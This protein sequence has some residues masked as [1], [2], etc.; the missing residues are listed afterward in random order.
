MASVTLRIGG[1]RYELACR[2]GE[3]AH[4]ERL[5]AIVDAKAVAAGRGL[6]TTNEAR[7]LLLIALLLA[8]DLVE[9]RRGSG[10]STD[11][12]A[13]AL[14]TLAARIETLAETLEKDAAAS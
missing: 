1:R 2:D 9:T 13:E 11:G 12:L 10:E 3:E 8:D 4:L 14:V 7:Q 5:A 6:G